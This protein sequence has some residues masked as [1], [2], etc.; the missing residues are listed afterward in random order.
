[1]RLKANCAVTRRT[2]CSLF[3]FQSGA[4]ERALNLLSATFTAAFQF[5]SGAIE[6]P[7]VQAQG[8]KRS[9]FQ[10]QS[11]AI[12]SFTMLAA[13]GQPTICFNSNLV[14]LKGAGKDAAG[15]FVDGFNSNLVRLKDC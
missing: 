7:G 14:R 13:I 4:I 11:G 15:A 2:I 5:Q 12:E 3:Q 9:P 8:Y 10:F 6:S 1:M